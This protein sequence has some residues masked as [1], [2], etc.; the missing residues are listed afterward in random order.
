[1]H[2]WEDIR[3]QYGRLIWSTA[4]RILK[5]HDQALDC[6]QEVFLEAW[7]RS[8]EQVVRDWPSFL[9]WL[10]AHRAL[11]R[12]RKRQRAAAYI[13]PDSDITLCAGGPEP[14]EEVEF[15]ELVE[16]VRL[17]MG[18][19]PDR[20]AEAF[21]LCCVEEMRYDAAARQMGTDV[22][23]IGVLIHRARSRLRELLAD[24][25]PARVKH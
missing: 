17:E 4:Y 1:M 23:S 15:R 16:R 24:L 5:K 8:Q 10:A 2:D 20:Q 25:S 6:C 19:L 3:G 9:R 7:Q 12:L 21:W 11:D 22:N 14:G 13:S 18:R